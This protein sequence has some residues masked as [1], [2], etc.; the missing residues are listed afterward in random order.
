MGELYDIG[1]STRLCRQC[2]ATR[3][4]SRFDFRADSG[5]R[6]WTCQ[7]CRR[8][9]Q[10][11]RHERAAP[12]KERPVRR[13]SAGA[14]E[15]TCT[16]C[17][18]AKGVSDFPPIHRGGDKLQS[19][20]RQCFGEVNTRNYRPYYE[21]ERV[22]IRAR[23]AARREDLRSLLVGYLLLHPCVDCGER[24]IV[25]LEF[26]HIRDKIGDVSALA[27][28]G[29]S[30]ERIKAEIDKCELR[31]ANCH[32][33]ATRARRSRTTAPALV[34]EPLVEQHLTVATQLLLSRL[35]DLRVCRECRKPK[36][37]AEFPFRSVREQRHQWRCLSCQRAYSASWYARNRASH[38]ARS[39]DN[40][41]SRKRRLKAFVR[42][43]LEAHPCV[44]CGESDPDVLD[45]DHVR[46]KL[47]EVSLLVG[48]GRPWAAISSEIAKCEV[49]CANCHRRRTVRQI[50]GYRTRATVLRPGEDSN[51][52]PAVP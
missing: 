7:D 49:R 13:R 5:T 29:R 41:R 50:G 9:Y 11:A 45:F 31:C 1:S 4:L 22:R 43:Y 18:L 47:A 21:R 37:L 51:L 24:D 23:V 28:G 46:G 48:A 52:R 26:D 32:R 39:A 2:G 8:T 34:T 12:R 15:F 25:V 33:R 42:K 3:D 20:C 16:R 27:S 19:W 40:R 6:R 17:G 44:D 36:S 14:Q 30:W 10:R 38:A 35:L